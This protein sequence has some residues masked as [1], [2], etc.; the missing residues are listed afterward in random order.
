MH[1]ITGI[2]YKSFKLLLLSILWR[3]GIAEG[4]VFSQV[5][6]GP[7]AERLRCMLKASDPGA[8]LDYPCMLF[9]FS[10]P[11]LSIVPPHKVR[12]GHYNSYQFVLTNVLL[13]F[14]VAKNI[15]DEMFQSACLDENGSCRVLSVSPNDVPLMR[16]AK[17]FWRRH[18]SPG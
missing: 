10:R 7:H 6:L 14:A 8:Q 5:T 13:W 1:R 18:L 9:L 17:V 3:S 12:L 11:N 15:Q 4:R 16:S 2:N